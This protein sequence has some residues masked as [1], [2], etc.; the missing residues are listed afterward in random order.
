MGKQLSFLKGILKNN[1][2]M[3]E[4]AITNICTAKCK[5][6]SIWQQQPKVT[7]D[8]DKALRA[9]SH[10]S[11]LGIRFITLTGGEPL[12]HPDFEKLIE[13]CNREHITSSILNAD[14]RIFTQRRLDAL[15]RCKP[16]LVCISVDHYSDEVVFESRSIPDL[17]SHAKR[18]VSELKQRGIKTMASTLICKY[19][20]DQ[21]EPLMKKCTEI[22][23]DYI[24]ANYPE[25]SESSVYTLGGDA[26]Y[27]TKEQLVHSLEDVLELKKK[28]P[29]VNPEI[30]VLNIID[31]LKNRTPKYL[32]LGGSRVFF[33]DWFFQISACMHLARSLGN[34]LEL[35]PGDIKKKLCNECSMSWYRDF[36]IYF[37]GVKS[38]RPLI[39]GFSFVL[40]DFFLKSHKQPQRRTQPTVGRAN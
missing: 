6:C 12:L 25:F 23:F 11:R 8:T 35:K 2:R 19:N 9:I 17:L 29:I 10:L 37:H 32:C 7:V 27:I 26:A 28:Y 33:V 16:D 38:L 24:S 15:G 5:F 18:A 39:S 20:H 22:G 30:S 31:Y 21:L 34:V 13:R 3:C 1:L 4:F 36:S 40:G 14:P